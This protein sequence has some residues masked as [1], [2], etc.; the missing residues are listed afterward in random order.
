MG[1]RDAAIAVY[2]RLFRWAVQGK[3]QIGEVQVLKIASQKPNE[4][5]GRIVV[6]TRKQTV[7]LVSSLACSSAIGV[8]AANG[9]VWLLA[10]L[11]RRA[12]KAVIVAGA[13]MGGSPICKE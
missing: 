2:I 12:P 6:A 8:E 7:Q 10:L 4:I 9:S 5:P 11:P 1:A 3:L 13:M